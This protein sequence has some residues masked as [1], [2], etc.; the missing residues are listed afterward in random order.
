MGSPHRR[1]LET[2]WRNQY[3][4]VSVRNSL[5]V[6]KLFLEYGAN[7]EAI[8]FISDEKKTYSA[9]LI[10]ETALKA[11]HPSDEDEI[12]ALL[13]RHLPSPADTSVARP[14]VEASQPR[15]DIEQEI[16]QERL[17]QSGVPIGKRFFLWSSKK[18]IGN[19]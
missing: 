8:C 17:K 16:P 10:I 5:E 3:F 6:V 14:L 11:Y 1:V 13:A 18:A 9:I 12:R 4:V 2:T 15:A 7:A 19:G